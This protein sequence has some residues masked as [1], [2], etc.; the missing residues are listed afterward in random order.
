MWYIP[1]FS[2]GLIFV[3]YPS[4]SRSSK[5][6]VFHCEYF[7][8]G[9]IF[10]TYPLIFFW[11]NICD[12]SLDFFFKF[13]KFI[14][15]CIDLE[16]CSAGNLQEQ[17]QIE[18][19]DRRETIWDKN[20]NLLSILKSSCIHLDSKINRL[21]AYVFP[22]NQ[23]SD[24]KLCKIYFLELPSQTMTPFKGRHWHNSPW[25]M[26]KLGIEDTKSW[27]INAF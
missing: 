4:G 27:N 13:I 18:K 2:S 10:V 14:I 7:A 12:I 21:L 19:L 8:S 23:H 1:W 25:T 17:S 26:D 6:W 24:K 5:E 3:I 15:I 9:L 11:A 22:R 20:P 16:L